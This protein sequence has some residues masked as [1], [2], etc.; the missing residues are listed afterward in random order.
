MADSDIRYYILFENYEQGLALHD[1]L[2]SNDI[3]NRIAPA[4]RAIQGKLSCGMSLL[5]EPTDIDAVRACIAEHNPAY[6]DIVPLEGQIKSHR[7]KYC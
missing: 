2:S 5:I 4:P 7:D 1:L 6:Y 3:K